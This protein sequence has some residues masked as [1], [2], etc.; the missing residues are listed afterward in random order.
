MRLRIRHQGE[1]DIRVP[2]QEIWRVC[3]QIPDNDFIQTF[4][5]NDRPQ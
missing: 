3:A 2:Q 4:L 1:I 5:E